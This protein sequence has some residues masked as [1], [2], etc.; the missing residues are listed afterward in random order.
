MYVTYIYLT[1]KTRKN[2]YPY[3]TCPV[4]MLKFDNPNKSSYIH[5]PLTTSPLKYMLN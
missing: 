3:L 4:D 5:S 1:D 2:Y